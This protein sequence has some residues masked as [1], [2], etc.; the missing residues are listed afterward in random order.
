[1]TGLVIN[2]S[3]VFLGD[4]CSSHGAGSKVVGEIVFGDSE[5]GGR[6][7]R[8]ERLGENGRSGGNEIRNMAGADCG[9]L[10]ACPWIPASSTHDAL[11]R[12]VS[13]ARKRVVGSPDGMTIQC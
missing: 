11:G 2:D 6:V 9:R 8:G 5:R 10:K 13:G 4:F 3:L 7:Y 12:R 1:M